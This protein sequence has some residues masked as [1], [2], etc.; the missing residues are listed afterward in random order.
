MAGTQ[1]YKVTLQRLYTIEISAENESEAATN[2][3][4]FA[5]GQRA[6]GFQQQ[7]PTEPRRE[8]IQSPE[9]IDDEWCVVE[10]VEIVPDDRGRRR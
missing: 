7:V 5:S 3:N 4:L 6:P 8:P 1:R 2:A 9:A 10:V